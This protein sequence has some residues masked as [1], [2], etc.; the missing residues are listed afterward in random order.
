VMCAVVFEFDAIV[1]SSG[2]FNNLLHKN[3][4]T[5]PVR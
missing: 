3:T 4:K 5:S 1:Q 2:V